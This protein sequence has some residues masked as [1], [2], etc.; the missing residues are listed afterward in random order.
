[1]YI[2]IYTYFPYALIRLF[3]LLRRPVAF[4]RLAD[5]S[6]VYSGP[7]GFPRH[8]GR[9]FE[10]RE[11]QGLALRCQGLGAMGKL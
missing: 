11:S 8:L 7:Q 4:G 3:Q 5:T 10:L 6:Q 2:Y 1:M 9:G